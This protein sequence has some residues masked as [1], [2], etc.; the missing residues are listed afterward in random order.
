M[1]CLFRMN[2]NMKNILY[3][4][5]LYEIKMLYLGMFNLKDKKYV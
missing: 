1:S 3:Y 4:I 2:I 5:C